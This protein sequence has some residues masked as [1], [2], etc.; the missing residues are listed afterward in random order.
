MRWGVRVVTVQASKQ[1][2]HGRL[3]DRAAGRGV[4][5]RRAR[6]RSDRA[7]EVPAEAIT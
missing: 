1:Q 6:A 4:A 7:P 3:F 2:A 5:G